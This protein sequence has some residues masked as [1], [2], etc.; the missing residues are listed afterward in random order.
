MEVKISVLSENTD[1]QMVHLKNFLE[2]KGIEELESVAILRKEHNAGQMGLGAI[3]STLIA[4]IQAASAPLAEL[5]KSLSVYVET[6][7]TKIE[8]TNQY[9]EKILLE[10]RHLD[11]KGINQL[12]STFFKREISSE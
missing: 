11:E 4:V 6:Y 8:L 12:I 5:V 10:T 9:G 2:K 7:K 3:G 1:K